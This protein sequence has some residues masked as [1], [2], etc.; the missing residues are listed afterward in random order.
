LSKTVAHA[1]QKVPFYRRLYESA[2]LN[3]GAIVDAGSLSKL[4]TV[5]REDFKRTS[6]QQRTAMDV[7]VNS[8]VQHTTSGSTG[9]PITVLNDRHWTAYEEALKLRSLWAYGVR[10]SDRVCRITSVHT[11]SK[12]SRNLADEVGL[13]AVVRRRFSRQVPL[14]TDIS[15]HINF[16]SFWKP[17]VV[18]AQ[19][20]HFRALVR[21]SEEQHCE[22]TF[23]IVLTQGEM[24]E[25]STRRL[26]QDEFNANVFD[27]Y[28]TEE[29]GY[30]AWECPTH[31]GYHI[32]VDSSVIEF[33]R[34]GKPVKHHEEGEVHV[35]SFHRMATPSIRYFTGDIATP[36]DENCPCGRGLPLMKNIQGR[37]EDFLL[38]PDGHYL[39]PHT[40]S[41]YLQHVPGVEQYKVI[42][43]N[44]FS[45]KVLVKAKKEEADAVLS[46]V[47]EHC[48]KLFGQMSFDI[49]LVDR[50]ENS[51]GPKF[52]LV[53]S[54]LT[55]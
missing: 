48:N 17:D 42:Q 47:Q 23:K 7:D 6:L 37:I 24:L 52:R 40:V 49:E 1:F 34:D 35:T 22:L 33:L 50:L 4:P 14:A 46:M 41:S 11:G 9:E 53:E 55:K 44:D 45:V 54:R 21:F 10:P 36:S 38:T 19:P 13:W 15:D 5:T 2:G 51:R 39:S 12:A 29:T 31:A 20:S 32:N 16:V 30:L 27:T 26:I 25:G 3:P 8:C 18:I 28:G 43:E